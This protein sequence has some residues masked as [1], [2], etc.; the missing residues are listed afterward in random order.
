MA[1]KVS[2]SDEDVREFD[3]DDEFGC[4]IPMR[5]HKMEMVLASFQLKS[6]SLTTCS[7]LQ[8][9]KTFY[10]HQDSRIYEVKFKRQRTFAQL[11]YKGGIT[12][13]IQAS[14]E[15]CSHDFKMN[16]SHEY[17]GQDT[18]CNM[19]GKGDQG[20]KDKDLKNLGR[21]DGVKRQ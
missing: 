5:I 16:A 18:R 2:S 3:E 15:D 11:F 14:G 13:K 8:L 20:Q 7:M 9:Q 4:D 21:N 1:N 12:P 10:K 6:D 19:V 17:V